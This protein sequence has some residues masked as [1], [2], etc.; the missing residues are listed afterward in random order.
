MCII[1]APGGKRGQVLIS[2][3][4]VW[5]LTPMTLSTNPNFSEGPGNQ[6]VLETLQPLRPPF[7][8]LK[9]FNQV[10]GPSLHGIIGFWSACFAPPPAHHPPPP[11]PLKATLISVYRR[12]RWIKWACGDVEFVAAN[13]ARGF[14]GATPSWHRA[15]ATKQQAGGEGVCHGSTSSLT[16]KKKK[17]TAGFYDFFSF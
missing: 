4:G 8:S 9:N 12:R 5:R 15:T 16:K 14:F 6:F 3:A 2:W 17:E 13:A 1:D 10:P 7:D 11:P